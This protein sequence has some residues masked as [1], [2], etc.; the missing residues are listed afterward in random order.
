MQ[1]ESYIRI[2]LERI[3]VERVDFYSYVPSPGTNTPIFVKPFPLDNSAPTEEGIK[4][5]VKYLRRKRS[6]GASGMRAEH[7]KGWLEALKRRKRE[8]AE[9][10]E[11][12]M[13]GKEGGSTEPNWGSLVD[14][15][16]K[17]FREGSSRPYGGPCRN[18]KHGR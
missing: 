8:A 18:R 14:L 11:A 13:Y 7:L 16:H 17:E 2:T 9:E 6:G 3:T 5:A 4:G 12:T 1:S 15:V 10:G